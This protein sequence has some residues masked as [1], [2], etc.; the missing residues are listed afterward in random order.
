MRDLRIYVSVA[1]VLLLIY[2][3]AQYNKPKPVNWKDSFSKEDKIPYGTYIVYNRLNDLFPRSAVR[4]ER[5]APYLVFKED[6]VSRGVYIIIAQS[7]KLDEYDFRELEKYMRKGNDVFIAAYYPGTFL[8]DSMKV[9]INTER[10]ANNTVGITT[11]FVNPSLRSPRSYHFEKGIGEQFFYKY[12]TARTV[13]LG[14]NSRGHANFIKYPFGKG[15]LYLM[16]S[17]Y[18]FTNYNMLQPGGAEY[19]SKALSY[20]RPGKEVI[21]DEFSSL[22]SDEETSLMHVFLQHPELKWAYCIALFSL[23]VF[24][25]YEMKRRQRVI[26]VADPLKNTSAEFVEVVGRVYYEQRNH[27]D[28]AQKKITYLL[29]YIRSKYNLKME[30]ADKEFAELL[31][32][33]SG[34][35]REL[36]TGLVFRI[37]QLKLYANVSEQE[38]IELNKDIESFYQKS[39]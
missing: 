16:A 32:N 33:K 19:A 28:I 9:K 34:V 36:A 27:A 29:E 12:D 21:W 15:A 20:L 11:N 35:D 39:R 14:T 3:A 17:P 22:G 10:P 18:F 23:L 7:L 5:K 2:L 6:S 24:V 1:S 26:P 31:L 8:T 38:L 13:I 30:R 37:A 25:L 4:P